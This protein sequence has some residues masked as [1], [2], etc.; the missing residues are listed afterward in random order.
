M[1]G[2]ETAEM[3]VRVGPFT[4]EVMY[5]VISSPLTVDVTVLAGP[6]MVTDSPIV[7]VLY[8]T[9]VEHDVVVSVTVS[10]LQL[11]VV[12]VW[13]KVIYFGGEDTV[14]ASQADVG[15]EVFDGKVGLPYAGGDWPSFP[16]LPSSCLFAS[17]G[18][19]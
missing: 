3:Y 6:V 9:S 16:R 19:A 7:L 18:L 17:L 12:T 2:P 13:C 10:V 11:V 4:T 8:R 15:A 14:V 5:L 1:A